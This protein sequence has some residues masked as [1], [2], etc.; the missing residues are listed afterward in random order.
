M[1]RSNAPRRLAVTVLLLAA[2]G[3]GDSSPGTPTN[4]SGPNNPQPI[5]VATVALD[6]SSATLVAGTTAQ[7]NATLRSATGTVLTGRAVSWSSSAASVASVSTEGLVTG[8]AP[9]TTTITVASEGQ[10][11]S[12]AITV[13]P[14]PVSA[15]VLSVSS[16][17]V[18]VGATTALTAQA[19]AADGAML[20]GRLAAA[21]MRPSPP[22]TPV[23]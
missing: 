21:R 9:G 18:Q 6:R 2:C 16:A 14:V 15:V 12:A 13:T 11:A 17:T 8:I 23:W 22:S 5:A 7:L 19:R 1:S 4:P 20:T 3:G 10:S